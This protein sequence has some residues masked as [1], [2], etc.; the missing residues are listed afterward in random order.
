MKSEWSIAVS[1]SSTADVFITHA[2]GCIQQQKLLSATEELLWTPRARWGADG[3]ASMTRV[4]TSD[5]RPTIDSMIKAECRP[6][7]AAHRVS[8]QISTAEDRTKG[9]ENPGHLGRKLD[10]FTSLLNHREL[11]SIAS[12]AVARSAALAQCKWLMVLCS[13]AV[14]V[15][16]LSVSPI[17]SHFPKVATQVNDLRK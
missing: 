14:S 1:A 8:A 16:R 2:T 3:S 11:S 4:F 10:S 15:V 13:F 12:Q 9:Q 5:T 17:E 6:H 7:C